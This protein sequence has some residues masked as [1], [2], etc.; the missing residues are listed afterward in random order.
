VQ[1]VLAEKPSVARELAKHLGAKQR[2]DGWFEGAGYQVTWAYGH[3]AGLKAPDDYD[4]ALKR[5]SVEA[6]PFIPAQ[7]ELKLEGDKTAQ[8]QFALIKKLMRSAKSLICATD[9]GREGELIF[10]YIVSLAG[11]ESKPAERLWLSSLT[12]RAISVAF[13]NLRPAADF[14]PLYDAARCRSEADWIIG[15]N[16]T[17]Y[18][19]V[20]F[21]TQGVLWSI[22]RVQTPVLAMIVAQDDQIRHF[23]PVPFWELVTTYRDVQFGFAGKGTADGHSFASGKDAV[24]LLATVKGVPLEIT[25]VVEKSERQYSPGLF[26]LTTLQR[27]MN[28]RYGSSAKAT[29]D[30]AQSLYEKKLLTYPRTDSRHLEAGMHSQVGRTLRALTSKL[31]NEIGVLDLD[32]LP[33][34]KRIFDDKR[35]TDHH[36]IIPTGQLPKD[37]TPEQQKVFDAVLTRL[38]SVFYPPCLRAVTE[39]FARAGKNP[40]KARGTRITDPGWTVLY[41]QKKTKNAAAKGHETHNQALPAFGKG[42]SG[43]HMPEIKSKETKPLRAFNENSLLGAMETAGKRVD[44]ESL[45]DALKERGLGT[46]AT[47]AAII[48]TLLT[49]GYVSREAKNLRATDLGR[50]LIA[51]VTDEQLTSPQMTGEWECDLKRIESGAGNAAAFMHGIA[52]YTQGLVSD[53]EVP[54]A[55]DTSL[56]RCPRCGATV[57]SGKRAYGCSQ[58]RAGCQFILP[59]SYRGITVSDGLARE[60]LARHVVIR[61]VTIEGQSR[62]LRLTVNGVLEDLDVP[63]SDRQRTKHKPSGVQNAGNGTARTP[64]RVK[65]ESRTIEARPV[66]TKGVEQPNLDQPNAATTVPALC[67]C[68]KCGD[69]IVEGTK[70]YGC[71]RWREGCEVTVWKQIAGKRITRTMAVAVLTKGKTRKL[72]GFVSKGGKSF[73]ASLVWRNNKAEFDFS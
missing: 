28:R 59:S 60:L 44:D 4:S 34:T 14:Q 5:W 70:G 3:L 53:R 71:T 41:P 23:A 43:P 36:A 1:L 32:A 17:R 52:Q 66:K 62:L 50:C 39:V 57:I 55:S 8:R 48:E 22:G 51:L 69:A 15:M 35:V 18:F 73:D 68:P 49:R 64:R 40:F 25:S 2:R 19:T 21:G 20:R 29:L 63:E 31:P 58:W 24:A 54:T 12:P 26:D 30:I 46:P 7:F 65:G 33:R 72:R 38:V 27:D 56:G 16:G 9:A 37:L 45:R 13:N 61:P 67:P 10:R 11:C 47:R 6:L 42:E